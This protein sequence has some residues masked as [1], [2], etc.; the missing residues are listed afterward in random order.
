VIVFDIISGT[1]AKKA[2]LEILMDD[3]YWPV[4]S[5]QKARASK[6][7][8]DMVGE[9]FIKE[10]DFGRVWLRLNANGEGEKEEIL[11]EKKIDAKKFLETALDGPT[12][13][14]LTDANGENQSTVVIAAK[15]VPVPIKLSPRESISSAFLFSRI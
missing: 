12:L 3:G 2:R 10:L 8:W 6:A 4:F 15:F 5:T 9:G 13:F 1:L 11:A 7:H 14:E